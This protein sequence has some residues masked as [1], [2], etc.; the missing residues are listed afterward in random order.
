MPP[1]LVEIGKVYRV[2][3]S[4][5][6]RVCLQLLCHNTRAT[7]HGSVNGVE[8]I[9]F[10]K[11]IQRKDQL[12]LRRH[13]AST[14][15]G[16]TTGGH[17]GECMRRSKFHNRLDLRNVTGQYDGRRCGFLRARPVSTVVLQRLV[18]L[19][20]SIRP[21]NLCQ[22]RNQGRVKRAVFHG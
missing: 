15:S 13:R 4:L 21:D 20:H 8:V 1:A 12:P 18:I 14:E 17:D 11:A 3:K 6:Q 7:A 22:A 16:A 19:E 10:V 5:F 2:K 9:N